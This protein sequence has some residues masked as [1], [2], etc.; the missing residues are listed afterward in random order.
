[1]REDAEPR[2]DR[3]ALLG[4]VYANH[5]ALRAALAEARARGADAIY[6]LGDAVGFGPHPD[7][8]VEV[9]AAAGIPGV[10]GNYDIAVVRGDP[11]CGCGYTDPRDNRYAQ[12]S[13]DYTLRG[14]GPAARAYLADL[15][16]ALRIR[17]GDRRV[18]LCHG[19]PRRVNEFLWESTTPRAFISRL[20]DEH[21]VDVI[22][23]AHTGIHWR[24]A[25]GGGRHIVN[26]GAV[27]RPA[28]D[29]RPEVW[30]AM[31]E[32]RPRATP[33]GESTRGETRADADGLSVEFVPV[34]YD[35]KTLAREMAEES[36]PPEF[37]E[38]ILTGW[39]ATCLEILPAKERARG[40]Y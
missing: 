8:A 27:G 19:S 22:A 1:M 38:T 2:F 12:I 10:A 18:L 20:L 35:Y 21:D 26:V 30:F 31:L 6:F 3:V 13:Y 36:L 17:V 24:R 14:T 32:A 15:A 16:P 33:G 23:C 37:I 11:D 25:L 4:G 39:W 40:R 9:L 28:N 7:R 5:V 34:A 29:G